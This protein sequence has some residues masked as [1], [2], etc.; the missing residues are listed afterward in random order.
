MEFSN[1]NDCMPY[2]KS[3]RFSDYSQTINDYRGFKIDIHRILN[4]KF[5]EDGVYILINDVNTHVLRKD[6]SIKNAEVIAKLYVDDV[7]VP[8]IESLTLPNEVKDN[9]I[10]E[11]SSEK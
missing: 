9:E 6:A 4:S 3:F 2:F 11:I 5:V 8:Q 7:L 10:E 1:F